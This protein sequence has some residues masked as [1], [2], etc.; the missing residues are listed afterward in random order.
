MNRDW[1]DRAHLLLDAYLSDVLGKPEFHGH[2]TINI[3]IQNNRIIGLDPETRQ[4][5]RK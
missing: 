2:V 1:V 3:V 5:I 4:T